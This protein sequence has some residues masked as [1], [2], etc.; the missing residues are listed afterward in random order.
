MDTT[1]RLHDIEYNEETGKYTYALIGWVYEVDT[2]E[3]AKADIDANYS[4]SVYF[5][6]HCC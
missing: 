4:E 2:L 5:Y 6:R 3:E 1:Y